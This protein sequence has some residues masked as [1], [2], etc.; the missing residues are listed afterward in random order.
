LLAIGYQLAVPV[1]P[2]DFADAETRDGWRR[3]KQMLVLK[4]WSDR[5]QRTPVD[6]FVYEPFDF[7]VELTRLIYEEVAP[8]VRAPIVSLPTLLEMKRT[9]GR[10]H[11]LIDIAEL[12][13][14]R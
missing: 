13:R 14:S 10:T 3:D 6:I 11:D 5:H 7:T 9:A 8:G 12:Q 1:Q 4:L 2:A